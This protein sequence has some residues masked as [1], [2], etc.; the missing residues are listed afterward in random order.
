MKK[1]TILGLA[2]AL[3][4]TAICQ[5]FMGINVDGSRATIRSK[6]L[7][8]QFTETRISSPNTLLFNGYVSGKP[9]EVYVFF[10][11]KSNIAWKF[12]VYLPKHIDWYELKGE[13]NKYLD[14]LT[15]KYG[16]PSSTYSTFLSPYYEGDGYEIS[17]V[18]LEK[19]LFSAFWETFYSIEITKY[20]QVRISY[21]SKTN[22]DIFSKENN[23]I[24]NAN[25]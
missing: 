18:G 10:T 5:D 12:A 25:F 20:K 11:P 7:A 23:Q 13:Y 21:E 9:I 8:K 3:S 6:F 4:L 14:L 1:I 17:A 19:S 16:A 2:L 15:E 24:N 22:S